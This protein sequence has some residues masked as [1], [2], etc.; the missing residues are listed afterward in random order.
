MQI[1]EIEEYR[2]LAESGDKGGMLGVA[3]LLRNSEKVEDHLEEIIYNYY[4]AF[5]KGAPEGAMGLGDVYEH[6]IGGDLG[7]RKAT[8]WYDIA[9][10]M[11]YIPACS[12]LALAY[13]N[14]LLG[15]TIDK[16]KADDYVRKGLQRKT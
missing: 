1:R 14:G 12:N 15:L 5:K 13:E 11:G 16:K 3:T 6:V 4:L 7:F 10:S 8:Y 2:K 9:C